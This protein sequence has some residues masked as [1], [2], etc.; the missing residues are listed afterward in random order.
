[1]RPFIS[2]RALSLRLQASAADREGGPDPRLQPPKRDD[3][4]VLFKPGA[5][6]W[7]TD[8]PDQA[9]PW[10]RAKVAHVPR[11]PAR[12]VTRLGI[13]EVYRWCPPAYRIW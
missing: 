13:I 11:L 6:T 5:S 12:P 4:A 10:V 7:N 8:D 3:S 9:P 1:M 2:F